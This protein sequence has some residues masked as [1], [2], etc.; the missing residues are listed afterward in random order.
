LTCLFIK[1]Q[2]ESTPPKRGAFFRIDEKSRRSTGKSE[3]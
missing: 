1:R 2:G 3:T